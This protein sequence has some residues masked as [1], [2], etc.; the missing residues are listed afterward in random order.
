[1]GYIENNL[2]PDEKIIYQ[3]KLHWRIYIPAIVFGI[4]LLPFLAMGKHGLLF[5]LIPGMLALVAWLQ[6]KNSEFVV[7]NKRVLIKVGILSRRTVELLLKKVETVGVNQ[8][9]LDR[10]LS[11]GTITIIGT[12]GT[13]ENFKAIVDPLMFR[14]HVHTQIGD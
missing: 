5:M 3:T 14:Q 8:G 11:S 7:T 9:I 6:I 12:G 4:I 1:M 10:I 2:L 13:K